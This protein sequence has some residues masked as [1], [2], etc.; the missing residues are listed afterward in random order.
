[1]GG[2]VAVTLREPDGTEHRMN[3]WTNTLPW[4]IKNIRFIR[5]EKSHIEAYL[6]QWNLMKADWEKH[7]DDKKFEYPM[8]DC[9][10]PYPTSLAPEGYGLVVIDM[11]NDVILSSQGY[12]TFTHLG[13]AAI[14]NSIGVDWEDKTES[15]YF[16]AKEFFNE[17][18][19]KYIEA[20]KVKNEYEL[21]ETEISGDGFSELVKNYLK[22]P[23]K[24]KIFPTGQIKL[25]MS[26][27]EIKEFDKCGDMLL[28]IKRLKFGLSEE[29][30][31]MWQE[32][33]KE[34]DEIE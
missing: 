8:T 21:I 18:R 12:T 16:R 29:E 22:N 33:I 17:N 24:N 30:W 25:D 32:W 6:D 1:M 3:R 19:A 34:E 20:K 26:P 28:D 27:F 11:K 10:S 9:Y 13:V 14:V 4:F 2:T 7:K 15:D 31:R 23:T 5:K